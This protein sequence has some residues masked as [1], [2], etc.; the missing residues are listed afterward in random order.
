MLWL[1]FFPHLV[2]CDSEQIL[3][4]FLQDTNV[5]KEST[6]S[7][8]LQHYK[9]PFY[10]IK[11][12]NFKT[13]KILLAQ[14]NVQWI[15]K[16]INCIAYSAFCILPL[17][18]VLFSQSEANGLLPPTWDGTMWQ[19]SLG[20][21][22]SPSPLHHLSSKQFAHHWFQARPSLPPFICALSPG[23]GH[24]SHHMTHPLEP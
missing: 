17:V 9:R 13:N 11:L 15:I 24:H 19:S 21:I 20:A 5:T 16:K 23:Q 2:Y 3:L 4:S 14:Y 12:F 8:H 18:S 6:V 1:P 22:T 10:Y 7:I